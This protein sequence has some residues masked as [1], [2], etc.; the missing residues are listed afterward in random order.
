M[1]EL[2]KVLS[3]I[4]DPRQKWKVKHSLKDV[5]IIVLAAMLGNADD[6]VEMEMFAR[7]HEKTLRKYLELLSGIPSHDTM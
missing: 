1:N 5:I 6:W 4:E 7:L 2:L 3:R